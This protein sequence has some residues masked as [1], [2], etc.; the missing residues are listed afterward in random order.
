MED[1][2]PCRWLKLAVNAAINAIAA[3]LQVPNGVVADVGYARD[4]ARAVVAEVVRVADALGVE[5]PADP[6]EEVLRVAAATAGDV[7]STA[8]DLAQCGKAEV[9]FINGA[10]VKC[11]EVLGVATPVNA[12]LLQ[13]IK[14]REALCGRG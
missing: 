10:V 4:L 11:G 13:L 12:A 5:V 6:F 1:A 14:T 2:E 3:I 9:D 7:S 8:R